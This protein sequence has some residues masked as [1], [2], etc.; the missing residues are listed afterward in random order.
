M[1][2]LTFTFKELEFFLMVLVRITCFVFAAP[3]FS[4]KNVPN[5]VKIGLGVMIAFIVYQTLTPVE[6]E[7]NTVFG[8]AVFVL[9]EA[10]TGLIIGFSASICTSIL[11]FAGQL[12]D[13]ETGL[14]MVTLFD[15]QSNES[16]T[17]TGA[18]YQY[19]VTLML[20]VSGMYQFVLRAVCDSFV[21][22]P[23]SG[24]VFNSEGL[25]SGMVAFMGDYL[26]IGFRLCLPVFVAALLLNA[27]LG[28]LAKVSPQL[29]M[30]AVG[31]QLKIVLGLAVLFLTV[32]LLPSVSTV[33]L[34]KMKE[35]VNVF[36]GAIS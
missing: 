25:L 14:S 18:Y 1:V 20:L 6:L 23:V 27:V 11:N 28:I 30:F 29:N 5:R 17:I 13:M 32:G 16:V 10:A 4:T 26:S 19:V 7:Y 34:S 21:L 33:I 31:I 2:D 8:Y 3:F 12:V 9:K 22:I 35:M 15:P 24:A 36:V